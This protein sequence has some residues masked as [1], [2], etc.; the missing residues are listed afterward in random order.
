MKEA[1]GLLLPRRSNL[2]WDVLFGP[3]A[4]TNA[5]GVGGFIVFTLDKELFAPLVEAKGFIVQIQT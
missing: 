4:P 2:F 1:A 3:R 5:K